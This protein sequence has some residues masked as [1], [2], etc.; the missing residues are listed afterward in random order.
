MWLRRCR[1]EPRAMLWAV[2]NRVIDEARAGDEA[3]MDESA[4]EYA[5]R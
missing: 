3:R 4:G 2:E 1:R 5:M